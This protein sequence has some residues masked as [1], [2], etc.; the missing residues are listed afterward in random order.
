MQT[1]LT[2]QAET[3]A[4]EVARTTEATETTLRAAA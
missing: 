1:V 3:V 4:G 2:A